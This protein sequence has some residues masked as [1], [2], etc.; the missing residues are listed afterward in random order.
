MQVNILIPYFTCI[1]FHFLLLK[2][3]SIKN[4]YFFV[5]VA[6]EVELPSDLD[7]KDSYFHIFII[8]ALYIHVSRA[9]LSAWQNW[10]QPG[11]IVTMEPTLTR[12][13]QKMLSVI[14]ASRILRWFEL[15]KHY[16]IQIQL[17][18]IWKFSFSK[19]F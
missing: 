17:Y 3:I 7:S 10:L 2:E 12:K 9:E 13:Y 5:T 18:V 14:F 11:V 16:F 8:H 4:R 15:M 6:L 1:F 19:Q